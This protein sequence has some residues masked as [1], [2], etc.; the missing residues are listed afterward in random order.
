MNFHVSTICKAAG[1]QVMRRPPPNP[2]PPPSVSPRCLG[3]GA[4]VCIWNSTRKWSER[5]RDGG[6]DASFRTTIA[7]VYPSASQPLHSRMNTK[8]ERKDG[9]KHRNPAYLCEERI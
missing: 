4:V 2:N 3:V 9:I 6:E 8:L 7:G 5:R 1:K